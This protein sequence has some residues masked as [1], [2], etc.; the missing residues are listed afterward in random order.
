MRLRF[1]SGYL[2]SK[3]SLGNFKGMEGEKKERKESKGSK[4]C[5]TI[6]EELKII[7]ET[8]KCPQDLILLKVGRYRYDFIFK[9]GT[10]KYILEFDGRFH[11]DKNSQLYS[12]EG[13]MRDK[14]KTASAIQSGYVM[15][16]ILEPKPKTDMTLEYIRI[17]IKEGL[18]AEKSYYSH[19]EEYRFLIEVENKTL[20]QI[21]AK[22]MSEHIYDY[23]VSSMGNLLLEK[24]D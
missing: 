5:R 15:I 9:K 20:K 12:K 4:L 19:F 6:L 13:E 18:K 8:E 2:S 11:V 24:K 23:L 14:I 21:E 22:P 17:H 16:R 1:F 3:Q 10:K 7:F